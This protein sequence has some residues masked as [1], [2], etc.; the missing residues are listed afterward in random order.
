[1]DYLA[2][3]HGNFRFEFPRIT[4][5]LGANGSGKSIL[6][7]AIKD[8]FPCVY[9]EGGRTISIN[10]IV[11]VTALNFGNY[12]NLDHTLNRYKNKRK[13]K[14]VDRI[15]DAIM[16]LLQ[17]GQAIKQV[18]S[19]AVE[20]WKKDGKQGDVPQRERPPLEKL[21]EQYNEVFPHIH[22][23]FDESSGNLT[24]VN[25]NKQQP[26]RPSELSDGEK[27]V[28]ALMADMF[29]LGEEYNV[30]VVDEPELNLHPELAERLWVSLESE[31]Q[32]KY[33]IYATHSIQ[34]A[35][36]SQVEA[37]YVISSDPSK[38]QKISN[39]SEIP[40][41]DLERYLGSVPGILNAEIVIVT[42]GNDKSFDS[43]FY[44]WVLG[45]SKMEVFP[46]GNCSDLIQVINKRDI[47]RQISTDI[48]LFGIIDSDYRSEDD[49][50]K[51]S[52]QHLIP[53]SLHEAESYI[54][55][56]DILVAAAHKIGSQEKMPT[57]TEVQDLIF[58]ELQRQRLLIAYNRTVPDFSFNARL[59]IERSSLANVRTKEE[60]MNLIR[61]KA[62]EEVSKARCMINETVVEQRLDSEL[63]HIDRVLSERDVLQ[64]LKL[65]PGKELLTKLARRTG[66]K[67]GID[68]IRSIKNNL[69]TDLF[70]PITRL[71]NTIKSS[72]ASQDT[73]VGTLLT[74]DKH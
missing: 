10:D 55:L 38:I 57:V 50:A 41:R 7:R 34:F 16:V 62:V 24:V 74:G 13:E 32:S 60:V 51:Y 46:C 21:F 5:I 58:E 26:Y 1:M 19:D 48:K 4:A 39:L 56:P 66:C 15:F 52:G 27:Q 33:F 70:D 22:L 31:Y 54:C 20:K 68:L 61:E 42:E 6:L 72:I 67:S 18:H 65:V 2:K 43:I 14:L 44:R 28:F 25:D 45:D 53:L 30:V 29:D 12:I 9:V 3:T 47:W 17:R 40:R 23:S 63:A 64:A 36:R 59:S 35:L 11:K 69:S 73:S 37:L 49:I 71:S 8:N